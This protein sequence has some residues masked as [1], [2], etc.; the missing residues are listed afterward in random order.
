M[1]SFIYSIGFDGRFQAV[2]PVC[3][4]LKAEGKA[5]LVTTDH[6]GRIDGLLLHKSDMCCGDVICGPM[7]FPDYQAGFDYIVKHIKTVGDI[8]S[9]LSVGDEL[10]ELLA[11]MELKLPELQEKVYQIRKV[12]EAELKKLML[13]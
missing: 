4:E 2:C 5:I 6:L 8:P 10:D 9:K 11:E 7:L 1:S 13:N 12:T 3:E